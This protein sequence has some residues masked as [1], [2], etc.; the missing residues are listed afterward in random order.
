MAVF[1]WKHNVNLRTSCA[2]YPTN[3]PHQLSVWFITCAPQTSYPSVSPRVHPRVHLL[4]HACKKIAH[5]VHSFSH[6]APSTKT[7]AVPR[8]T[9]QYVRG[10]G[11]ATNT[12]VDM[13]DLPWV[14]VAGMRCHKVCVCGVCACVCVCAPNVRAHINGKF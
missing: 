2:P 1:V 13:V 12:R 4:V 10:V 11:G 9:T 7:F 14:E 5:P 8:S 6:A 3:C